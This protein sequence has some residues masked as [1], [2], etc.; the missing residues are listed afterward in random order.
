MRTAAG[1]TSHRGRLRTLGNRTHAHSWLVALTCF[2]G[3][4]PRGL[5]MIGFWHLQFRHDRP[6]FGQW[7]QR[8]L[9]FSA[10]F[11][12]AALAFAQQP[13]ETVSPSQ[14]A[15]ISKGAPALVPADGKGASPSGGPPLQTHPSPAAAANA[16]NAARQPDDSSAPERK[17]PSFTARYPADRSK[18]AV[19]SQSSPAPSP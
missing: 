16:Q 6:T 19:P 9:A 8:G 3:T 14:P 18:G 15:E 7:G 13:A 4:F 1:S 11:L 10:L 5:L 17:D 12:A 2:K